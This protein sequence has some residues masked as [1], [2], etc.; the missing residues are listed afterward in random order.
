MGMQRVTCP[1]C[2]KLSMEMYYSGG[3]TKRT[4]VRC[5]NCG[6]IYFV[7]YGNGSVISEK[8]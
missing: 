8:R 3:L 5:E 7:V 4:K 1:Y 2:E 6:K